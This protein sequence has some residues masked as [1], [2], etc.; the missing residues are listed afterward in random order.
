MMMVTMMVEKGNV[1]DNSTWMDIPTSKEKDA[2]EI[3][4]RGDCGVNT[5][6]LTE[7]FPFIPRLVL[8]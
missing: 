7:S 1:I 5:V 2:P 8:G 3:R 6:H 4:S